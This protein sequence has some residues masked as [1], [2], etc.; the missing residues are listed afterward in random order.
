MKAIE[1]IGAK[2]GVNAFGHRPRHA[3]FEF[4]DAALN[5]F[6]LLFG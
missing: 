1:L 3:R 2:L 5:L 4:G 6:G